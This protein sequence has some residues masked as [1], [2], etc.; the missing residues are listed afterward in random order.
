MALTGKQRRYLRGLGHS[1]APV[2]TVGKE[3]FSPTLAA[4]I[5]QALLDHELIKVRIGQNAMID[6]HLAAER[7][8]GDSGSEAVQVLGSTIL[9]YRE[10]AEAPQIRLPHPRPE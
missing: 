7:L 10:H 9:L 8:A 2:V 6:R 1:L 5:D 3:G 4:A